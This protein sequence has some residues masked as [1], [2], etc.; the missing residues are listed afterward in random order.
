MPF[1]DRGTGYFCKKNVYY[2]ALQTGEISLNN[3]KPPPEISQTDFCLKKLK[4]VV[5]IIPTYNEAAVIQDTIRQVFAQLETVPDHQGLVLIFDSNSGDETRIRV[6]AIQKDY[7][8]LHLQGE[9]HKSGLGSAYLQAMTYALDVLEA[10]I[11][12]EYDAD[13][14]HQPKYIPD[15][16]KALQNCDVVLGSRYV[17]GG[18]IPANWQ[19]HRKIFSILGNY[20]A[21]L[22]LTSKYK[23][24]TSGF[25]ATRGAILKKVLPEKFLSDH[26][27]YKIHLLWLLHQAKARVQEYP[28]E[29]VDRDKGVSKL[30]RNS[31]A[32]SL[33]VVGILRLKELGLYFKMCMVGSIGIVL[34]L[35]VYNLLRTLLLPYA[36][37]MIAVLTAILSNFTLNSQFTFKKQAVTRKLK[38]KVKKLTGFVLYSLGII[39]LQS[40]WVTAGTRFLGRGFFKEN[41]LLGVGIILAS[42]CNYYIYSRRI[43]PERIKLL[44][45]L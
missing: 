29:F 33:R 22:F 28:I 41:I 18:S 24:F 39:L 42:F 23:D 8:D 11:I 3:P 26:Y 25:R 35:L 30:P 16:I 37:S 2:A 7:P 12:F 45:D 6:E 14:S 38:G 32:D 44:R 34:Q 5:V 10:D 9:A 21:R 17:P 13:L 15:M 4:K 43:W 31:V 1:S 19:F 27:A 40:I 36:A 20:V